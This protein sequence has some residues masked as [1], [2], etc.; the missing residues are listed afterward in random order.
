[1][2][3]AFGN[4]FQVAFLRQNIFLDGY[5]CIQKLIS[6]QNLLVTIN[7]FL[8]AQSKKLFLNEKALSVLSTRAVGS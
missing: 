3:Y 5:I 6:K 4:L 7:L 8:E 2:Y 1:M